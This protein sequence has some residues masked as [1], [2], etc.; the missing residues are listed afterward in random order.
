[1]SSA[2]PRGK[3]VCA[4]HVCRRYNTVSGSESKISCVSPCV[5]AITISS[6]SLLLE[7]PV[8]ER[9]PSTLILSIK[10]GVN[11]TIN[12]TRSILHSQN[13]SGL[14]CR[15]HGRP[16]MLKFSGNIIFCR[17]DVLQKVNQPNIHVKRG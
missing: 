1:M 6:F 9:N 4:P 14:S 8:T 5:L 16:L 12:G 13:A 3:A 2:K 10:F 11:G 15:R 17:R 7:F